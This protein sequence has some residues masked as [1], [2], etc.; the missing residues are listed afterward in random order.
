LVEA[1]GFSPG[2]EH[3]RNS[4]HKRFEHSSSQS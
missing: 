2:E 3:E 1:Q 4:H